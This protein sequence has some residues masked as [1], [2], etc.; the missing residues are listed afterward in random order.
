[1]ASL[2][3]NL[4]WIAAGDEI[5]FDGIKKK[6][7]YA[8]FCPPTTCPICSIDGSARRQGADFFFKFQTFRDWKR[9]PGVND[10]CN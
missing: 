8:H 9:P 2:E 6:K 1:M 7:I 5:K 10:T 3:L 4:D